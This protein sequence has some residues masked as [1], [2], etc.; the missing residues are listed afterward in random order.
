MCMAL[1]EVIEQVVNEDA[2]VKVPEDT[3]LEELK[4]IAFQLGQESKDMTMAM[5]VYMLGFSSY[6][7][8]KDCLTDEKVSNENGIE[9]LY[10]YA[11]RRF[12]NE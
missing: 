4:I 10:A 2:G 6:Y 8:F 9:R 3:V 5:A 12:Q 7:G 1:P 11:K